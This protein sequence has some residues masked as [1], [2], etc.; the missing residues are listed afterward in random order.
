MNRLPTG[1]ATTSLLVGALLII[2]AFLAPGAAAATAPVAFGMDANSINAQAAAGVKADYGTFWL[3]PWTLTSGWGGP[4]SQLASMKAAGVTPAIHFY[5]WGDDISQSCLENGCWSSLHN[6]QKDKA[7]WQ[8]LAQQLVDHLNAKMGG[9]PVL[10]FV[11]TE[12]NKGNVAT[13]E[14][15][16]GYLADKANFIR[17]GY[18]A[19]KIVMPLGNWNSAAW[20]TFDRFAAASDYTGIQGMRG[21]TH[22]TL[23]QYGTLYEGLQTGANTLQ[24]LFGKPI[25]FQDIALSSYPEPDYLQPQ[26]DTLRELFTHLGDLKAAGVQAIL[27]RTWLDN[28][29]MNTANYYGVA[30]RYW[31][32][33]NANGAKPAQK[34]WVDGVKAERA[35]ASP[36]NHAP[37]AS[38]TVA[39]SGL[40]A[41][42]DGGGSSDADGTPLTYAWAFGDGATGTGRT[43]SHTFAAGTYTARLTVSD[44]ALTGTATKT[45]T[46]AASPPPSS[47]FTATFAVA[48]GSNEWW[49]EVKVT[50]SATPAKVELSANGGAWQPLTLKSWGNWAAS[51]HVVKGT[52][53]VFRATDNAGH[54]A[55]SPSQPWL[56]TA[57]TTTP[58]PA[59]TFTASF[60]PKSVGNDWWVETGVTSSQAIAKVEARL[61]GGAWT[62]LPKDSWGTYADSLHAPNGTQVQFRATA[63]SGATSLSPTVAWT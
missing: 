35:G 23:A 51:V 1:L 34:V 10:V 52:P 60:S 26:A 37:V 19:A 57:T 33:A 31:G 6:A 30:E 49:E 53:I 21:S 13:Y 41:T 24:S 47:S 58:P 22:Q 2:P 11:E 62:A 17:A 4:D 63:T 12:F 50:A 14:P 3:G 61:D 42:F 5:Y 25:V 48:S 7:H 55:S 16:D 56:G 18:P 40:T 32:L 46:L 29:N 43:A 38:F 36:T 44:G 9:K 54:T 27:Y 8:T 15:L 39:A 45:V 20:G 28:P 59:P